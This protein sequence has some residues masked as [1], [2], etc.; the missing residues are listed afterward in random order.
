MLCRVGN[1]GLCLDVVCRSATL[2]RDLLTPCSA[3]SPRALSS[4]VDAIGVDF[5]PAGNEGR[6]LFAWP[7]VS[8]L[9]GRVY[10]AEGDPSDRQSPVLPEFDRHQLSELVE[11]LPAPVSI[12]EGLGFSVI[13]PSWIDCASRMDDLL[14]DSMLAIVAAQST[15]VASGFRV[16][17]MSHASHLEIARQLGSQA[18]RVFDEAVG[19]CHARLISARAKAALKVLAGET[20]LPYEARVIRR[21]LSYRVRNEHEAIRNL[22][23]TASARLDMSSEDLA[24][25][26]IDAFDVLQEKVPYEGALARR[27]VSARGATGLLEQV[28]E[29]SEVAESLPQLLNNASEGVQEV[30]EDG[31]LKALM[32]LGRP[33]EKN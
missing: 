9:E 15:E 25:A 7:V 3:D 24:D 28:A 30:D 22:L 2:H 14:M 19:E 8:D 20:A 13:G 17:P 18:L 4:R 23:E 31:L 16:V 33:L 26:V 6:L 1:E 10:L 5:E 27:A 29:E 12:K 32:A 21:L 11:P